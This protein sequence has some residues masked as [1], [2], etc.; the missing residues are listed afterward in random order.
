MSALSISPGVVAYSI[1]NEKEINK[2]KEEAKVSF[3][4][5]GM[6]FDA[7]NSRV[8]IISLE[9]ISE[10]SKVTGFKIDANFLYYQR[11]I[12]NFKKFK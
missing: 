9:Q 6:I 10:F 12:G 11:T 7:E 5:Y 4:T 2:R 3:F 1:N 8:C